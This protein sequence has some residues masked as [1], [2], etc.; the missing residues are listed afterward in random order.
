MPVMRIDFTMISISK[1]DPFISAER[2]TETRF[3]IDSGIDSVKT[4][5]QFLLDQLEDP[6]DRARF[7]TEYQDAWMI[8]SLRHFSAKAISCMSQFPQA[9]FHSQLLPSLPKLMVRNSDDFFPDE[10]TSHPWHIFCNAH[11]NVLTQHLNILP[12]WDM[13]QTSHEYSVF[14]AAGRCISGGPIC[15][16]DKP[17]EHDIELIKQM[18][19]R[20]MTETIIIRPK[21]ARTTYV[22]ASKNEPRFLRIS[23]STINTNTPMLGIF[24]VGEDTRMEIVTLGHFSDLQPAREYIIRAHTSGVISSP[25]SHA[26]IPTP[27]LLS[28]GDKGYEILTAYPLDTSTNRIT[29][30]IAILGLLDKMTGAA[31]VLNSSIQESPDGVTIH[32]SLKAMGLLGRNLYHLWLMKC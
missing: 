6:E 8:A 32:V 2:L 1:C 27:L 14:H 13:F 31:A 22:Y 17:G 26:N 11:T 18:T 29:R 23:T 3:L 10:P 19:A 20:T 16:T 9:L 28:L 4:D 25:I 30:K 5:T 21:V 7:T 12:D 15:F 24:N